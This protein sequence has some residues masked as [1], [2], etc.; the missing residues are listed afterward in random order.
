MTPSGMT[1]RGASRAAGIAVALTGAAV[2]VGWIFDIAALKSI[3]SHLATMKVNT[4][5]CFILSGVAL[6]LL[7][8]DAKGVHA[9][10]VL[11]A[12]APALIGAASLAEDVLGRNF[13][14]DEL[15]VRDPDTAAPGRPGRM[16]PAT[17]INFMVLG[18]SLLAVVRPRLHGVGQS[19]AAAAFLFSL[20]FLLG[21]FFGVN[22][23]Y[24]VRGFSTI[25]LHTALA[26]VVLSAGVLCA[27]A[28]KGW[29]AEFT[30]DTS[31]ARMGRRLLGALF[32]IL[33][34]VAW[35]RLE[36][37][38]SGWY[39][40][41]VGVGILVVANMALLGWVLVWS[42]RAANRTEE[43]NRR[44]AE[45]LDILHE[46]DRGLIANRKPQEIAEA[47]LRPVRKL[48]G[49]PRAIVN[50]FDLESGEAEWL[51]AI[52]RQRIRLGGVRYPIALMGDLDALR[53]GEPQ[54]IDTASL[55]PS[56]HREA[57][58]ASGVK[59]YMVMPMSAGGELIGALSFGG[60]S[61]DFPP[62]QTAIAREVATQLAIAIDQARLQE[63]VLRQSEELEERVRQRT[64]ELEA[65][66]KELESFS[67]TVSHDL[68]APLRAVDGFARIFE[69]DYG[70]YV[71]EE[72]RR[73]I[74]VIRDSS[75]RMGTLIDNL[76]AFSKLGRQA[77]HPAHTDMT[78]LAAEAWVELGADSRVE[79]TLPALPAARCDRQLLKQVWTNLF[80]NAIK[81][82]ANQDKPRVDVSG[83][84]D[85][86]ETVYC[87]AD[88]GAGFD[89]KYYNKLFGVFQRLHA[90]AEYAGNGV[91]LATVQRIVS[92][93]G[94]RAWAES[95]MG[96]GAR[97][98]FSLPA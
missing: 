59:V 87:V 89:M 82:S 35:L 69:E 33:P 25:A 41:E 22:A 50:L 80:S 39:T 44:Y 53:R 40:V 60:E 7:S 30:R 97:F 92:R 95:E 68:R 88:N 55:E 45:R 29:V 12:A 57:L 85:G 31:A 94:G 86:G 1:L 71:D 56:P 79:C 24:E 74:G 93:H 2:L 46:V 49:V 28:D 34:L 98:F 75:R 21:F 81:Y 76:L 67:Y 20:L 48:L 43:E 18:A 51:A 8:T 4:A 61:T 73:L 11:L 83:R 9:A 91:G 17:A 10:T 64:A 72:G 77:L 58:L 23:L 65:A 15:L 52:G 36:G 47:A 14:L 37:L 6:A 63:R 32:I 66:N 27:R 62:E 84:T 42:T 96:A 90:E 78:L 54:R 13:G 26:M 38:R 5:V 19:L 70:R 3:S 16:A